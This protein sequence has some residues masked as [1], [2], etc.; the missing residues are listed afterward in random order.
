MKRLI[1]VA[2]LAGSGLAP[3]ARAQLGGGGLGGASA[4]PS[5]ATALGGGGVGAIAA[6]QKTI[7]GFFGLSK[8]NCAACKQK[9][10][11]SQ[12]GQLMNNGL[13]PISGISGG[14]IPQFCPAAPTA[15]EAAA[16]ANTPG[17]SPAVAAAAKIKASEADAKARVAAVEYLGTV[18][19]N[20]WPEAQAGLLKAL[21]EDPNECVRYAAARVLSNGCCCS[22]ETIRKLTI[23]VM[24][25]A[26][27]NEKGKTEDGAPA[28]GSERVRCAAMVA[29]QTCL[30]VVP[31]EP[32]APVDPGPGDGPR[33]SPVPV[34]P[35]DGPEPLPMTAVSK[36]DSLARAA[37]VRNL[38]RKSAAEIVRDARLALQIVGKQEPGLF[39]T[40]NRTVL[41]AIARARTTP[42][43]AGAVPS[44]SAPP[45]AEMAPTPTEAAPA[46]APAP[47]VETLP[48]A[49]ASPPL[50][51]NIPMPAEAAPTAGRGPTSYRTLAHTAAKPVADAPRPKRSLATVL[52]GDLRGQ[53][54]ASR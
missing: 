3:A 17:V 26:A 35:P 25:M 20:V 5:A 38:N 40:G 16:L 27:V 1:L 28:E 30:P 32:V 10:C 24:G 31:P 53:G 22:R 6:P 42:K 23:T 21:R 29:L 15:A 39:M 50:P 9:L 46:P 52:A 44:P 34:K 19:C 18:D 54:V 41:N 36:D 49:P 47:A 51:A 4:A 37:F 8:A 2:L 45:A 14:L 48:A 7:W 12:L 13:A 33:I 43:A 11:A